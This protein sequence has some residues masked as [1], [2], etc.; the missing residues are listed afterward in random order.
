MASCGANVAR[1]NSNSRAQQTFIVEKKRSRELLRVVQSFYLVQQ[2]CARKIVIPLQVKKSCNLSRNI[3]VQYF[4]PLKLEEKVSTLCKKSTRNGVVLSQHKPAYTEAT[5][6]IR[7]G[8]IFAHYRPSELKYTALGTPRLD[9][10]LIRV[11]LMVVH[12]KTH[13]CG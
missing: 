1:S 12:E 5:E 9:F 4:L 11:G 10:S 7:V 3:R 6:L 13:E 2:R 8:A